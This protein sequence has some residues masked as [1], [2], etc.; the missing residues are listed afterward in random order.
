MRSF[1]EGTRLNWIFEQTESLYWNARSL[2]SQQLGSTVANLIEL[3]KP[4]TNKRESCVYIMNLF[5][6]LCV[7]FNVIIKQNHKI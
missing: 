3:I 5:E 4:V 1:A 6:T 7:V 2:Y